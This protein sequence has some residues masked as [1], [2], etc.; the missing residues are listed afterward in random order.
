MIKNYFK[1]TIRFLLKNRTFSFI[2]FIGL[3]LGTLC[4]LYILLYLQEQYS[5]D[6]WED[7]ASDIYRVNT[8]MKLLGDHH[9]MSRC[10]PPID[11]GK[12]RDLPRTEQYAHAF[13]A[14]IYA[15]D[16]HLTTHED[17][18]FYERKVL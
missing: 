1:T 6:R 2:N 4:C 10:S 9:L 3:S 12:K 17:R 14:S 13:D 11:A 18:W 15:D 7:R 8:D 5:Y 16:L